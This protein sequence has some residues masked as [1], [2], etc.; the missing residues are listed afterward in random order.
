MAQRPARVGEGLNLFLLI[1]IYHL[2]V[3]ALWSLQFPGYPCSGWGYCW[4]LEVLPVPCGEH[5]T[6]PP[7]GKAGFPQIHSHTK[8]NSSIILWPAGLWAFRLLIL[9][10]LIFQEELKAMIEDAGFF[11]VDYENLNFG[12]VAIHSGFKLW[13][14][15]P[16]H[17]KYNFHGIWKLW[18]FNGIKRSPKRLCS[19]SLLSSWAQ[20]NTSYL[21]PP[22]NLWSDSSG[23]SYTCISLQVQCKGCGQNWAMLTSK[24]SWQWVWIK[25]QTD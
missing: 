8:H 1:C 22:R 10:A 3:Q 16:K 13:V 6:V 19:R 20:K 25:T 5:P 15:V 11:R 18:N 17:Q 2:S 9:M 14:W 23:V 12:I 24:A 21:S 4:W 7:S